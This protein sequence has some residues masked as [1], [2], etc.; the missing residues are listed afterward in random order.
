M[1]QILYS[2]NNK[3]GKFIEA[4]PYRYKNSWSCSN[5]FWNEIHL[6]LP[7]IRKNLL[8]WI[9]IQ[10]VTFSIWFCSIRSP[11]AKLLQCC[12]CLNIRIFYFSFRIILVGTLQL[13]S[14]NVCVFPNYVLHLEIRHIWMS[15]CSTHSR[16]GFHNKVLSVKTP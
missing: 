13:H 2:S 8:L 7:Q 6:K 4:S 11:L 14:N 10:C 3:L 5:V 12:G 15:S 9:A 1:L 16:C